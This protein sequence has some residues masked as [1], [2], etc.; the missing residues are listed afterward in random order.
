VS[1]HIV[2]TLLPLNNDDDDN[3]DDDDEKKIIIQYDREPRIVIYSYYKSQ[4][5][6]LFLSRI[7]V[8]N[9]TC[10]GQIVFVILVTLNVCDSQH[11]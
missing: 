10:F 1:N 3:D 8:K 9:S 5:D 6:E 2:R 4:R 7:L 11:K